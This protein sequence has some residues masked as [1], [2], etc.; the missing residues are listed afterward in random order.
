M[1]LLAQA[2]ITN[3][4]LQKIDLS[5]MFLMPLSPYSLFPEI[6]YALSSRL[7]FFLGNEQIGGKGIQHLMQALR[8]NSALQDIDLSVMLLHTLSPKFSEF[9]FLVSSFILGLIYQ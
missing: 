4:T 7:S 1:Q 8:I 9:S 6:P 2:L 3:S 5:C